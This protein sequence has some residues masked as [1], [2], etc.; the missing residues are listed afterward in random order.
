MQARYGN[1]RGIHDR[2]S[3]CHGIASPDPESSGAAVYGYVRGPPFTA[4]L[5]SE[6]RLPNSSVADAALAPDRCIDDRIG[7]VLEDRS[8]QGRLVVREVVFVWMLR[9]KDGPLAACHHPGR[10]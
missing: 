8:R 1:H 4:D 5:A 3:L 10:P 7:D 6:C 2:Y 9:S